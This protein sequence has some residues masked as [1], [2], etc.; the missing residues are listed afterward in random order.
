MAWQKIPFEQINIYSSIPS[1]IDDSAKVKKKTQAS[2][3]Q[4]YDVEKWGA[5]TNLSQNLSI[6][7]HRYLTE[8]AHESAGDRLCLLE[9]DIWLGSATEISNEYI[10]RSV[11]MLKKIYLENNCNCIVEL[12]AGYGRLLSPLVL[13]LSSNSIKKIYALDYT[14]AALRILA[15][16]FDKS[17]YDVV[18]GKIDLGSTIEALDLPDWDHSL[19]PLVFTSQAIMYVPKLSQHFMGLMSYWRSGVFS[20]IEPSVFNLSA[21]PLKLLQE[22]YLYINDYNTNLAEILVDQQE[23]GVIKS[24]VIEED[25]LSEN[26][27]LPLQRFDWQ[28]S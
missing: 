2:I 10:D 19:R 16:I 13:S 23:R 21:S 17:G 9:D 11:S 8:R 5:L 7:D 26:A 6:N 15:N 20:F 22:R 24:L 14:D 3:M 27:F 4:E 28:F 1:S 25:I 12:G 18:M